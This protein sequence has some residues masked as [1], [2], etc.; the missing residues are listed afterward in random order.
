MNQELVAQET[1]A[2]DPTFGNS[3]KYQHSVKYGIVTYL[4]SLI[5]KCYFVP[6]EKDYALH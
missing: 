2:S 3:R 4:K 6:K 5:I 1:S